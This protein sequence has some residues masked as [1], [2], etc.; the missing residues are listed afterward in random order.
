MKCNYKLENSNNDDLA[1]NRKPNVGCQFHPVERISSM[2]MRIRYKSG[3]YLTQS[4]FALIFIILR[5]CICYIYHNIVA[6]QGSGV[7][8][9]YP[10]E[11]TGQTYPLT[12]LTWTTI[13][14]KNTD[15]ID[16]HRL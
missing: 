14:T 7:S 2:K 10:L 13:L 11:Q 3:P 5:P 8:S 15:L 9:P 12:R 6:C 4:V 1:I 16:L